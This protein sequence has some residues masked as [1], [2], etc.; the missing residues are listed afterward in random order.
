MFDIDNVV[1][2]CRYQYQRLRWAKAGVTED[3]KLLFLLTI[4]SEILVQCVANM[5]VLS[6]PLMLQ[7]AGYM[8]GE[9]SYCH[10]RIVNIDHIRSTDHA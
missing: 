7:S 3:K 4:Q 9:T 5:G 8:S 6:V 2:P 1:T 10:R